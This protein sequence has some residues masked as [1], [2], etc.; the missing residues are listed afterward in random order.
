MMDDLSDRAQRWVLERAA[1]EQHLERAFVALVGELGLVQPDRAAAE[2]PRTAPIE[3]PTHSRISALA[4]AFRGSTGTCFHLRAALREIDG[5]DRLAR[6]KDS[7]SRSWSTI[8]LTE[9]SVTCAS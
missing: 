2:E 7:R 5:F 1:F 6:L 9:S 3:L 8:A 4:R